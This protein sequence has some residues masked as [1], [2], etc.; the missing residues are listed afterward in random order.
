MFAVF[1][2]DAWMR[3]SAEIRDALTGG[4]RAPFYFWLLAPASA[5]YSIVMRARAGLYGAGAFKVNTLPKK[6]ISVGGLTAGGVG[7]TPMVAYLVRR[8]GEAGHKAAVLTRGYGGTSEGMVKVV[9]DGKGSFIPPSES[10]DEA[11]MLSRAL[12]DT[13]VVMGSDRYAAGALAVGK[14]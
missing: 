12:P 13:P 9:S 11:A 6:V 1:K 10:G 3:I 2:G 4:A 14:F 7:K 8:L 5:L